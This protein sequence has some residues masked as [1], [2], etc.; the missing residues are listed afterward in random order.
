M[1]D[2]AGGKVKK[3][4]IDC[5]PVPFRPAVIDL[6]VERTN[7]FLG[8]DLGAAR[9]RQ[10]LEALEMEVQAAGDGV[11]R[12]KAPSFRVDITR[13]IDLVEEVARLEGYDRIPV[14]CPP[15]KPSEEKDPFQL[16]LGDKV[17]EIMVG[18]GF[19]EVISYSFIAPE[20]VEKLGPCAGS[21]LRTFVELM[22]PLTVEQSVMRTTLVP[23]LMGAVKTNHSHGE[24]DLRL[25]EWGKVFVSRGREELPWERLRLCAVMTGLCSRKEWYAEE[26]AADLYDIKGVLEGLLDA[27]GMPET[28]FRRPDSPPAGYSGECCAEIFVSGERVATAG[29]V[30]PAVR[31]GY[32]LVGEKV[33]LFFVDVEAPVS[34]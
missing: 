32:G 26:R 27:L 5:Y 30:Y 17:R 3:G 9:M 16:T 10:Y 24:K 33:L 23:G 11:L 21:E 20:S 19:S 12:V 29:E 28:E 1:Q 6:R 13:E 8:T 25:F 14:T 22:N 18:F 2:L 15:V 4:I 7:R 31:E 34:F